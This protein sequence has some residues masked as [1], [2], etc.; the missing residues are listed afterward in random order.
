MKTVSMKTLLK[1]SLPQIGTTEV[2]IEQLT[3]TIGQLTEHLKIHKK[4]FTS[5]NGLMK[6][7]GQ[8]R[9]LLNYLKEGDV[10][11]Y[12]TIITKLNLKK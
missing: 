3:I 11:R 4:D 6:V 1:E 10:E 7:L 9:N 5:K 2:Q 12:R 8:R